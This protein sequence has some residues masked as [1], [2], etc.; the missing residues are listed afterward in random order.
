MA[1]TSKQDS[2]RPARGFTL[3]EMMVT[4][5]IIGILSAIA[6]PAY[7]AYVLR[8]R[9]TEAFTVL[10]GLQPVAEQWW[11]NNR[12]FSTLPVPTATPNFTYAVTGTDSS[13]VATATGVSKM[14]G[15]NYTIDQSGNRATTAVPSAWTGWTTSTTC[16]VDRKGGLCTE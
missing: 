6:I 4:V 8:A 7:S 13:Y 9:T 15:L 16:W 5:A 12:T 3:I 1:S 14:A 10:G 11:S 2:K